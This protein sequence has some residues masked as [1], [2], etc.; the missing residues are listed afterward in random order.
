MGALSLNAAIEAGYHTY[1]LTRGGPLS[2]V[3][4]QAILG[5][6][7]LEIKAGETLLGPSGI[8]HGFINT[9]SVPMKIVVAF[10]AAIEA[11]WQR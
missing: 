6:Q 5:D 2:D 1:R 11:C 7:I 3:T 10:P 4:G 9:G 8:P